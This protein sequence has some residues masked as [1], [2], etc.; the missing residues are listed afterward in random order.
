ML[1]FI[2]AEDI[3][4]HIGY[5]GKLPWHLPADL[6]HFKRMTLHHPIIMGRRTFESFPGLLP[7]RHH[8]LLTHDQK[9]DQQYAQNP[10]MTVVHSKQALGKLLQDDSQLFFIIGGAS[11]FAA[12]AEQVDLLY[13]TK[14]AAN[15]SGDVKMPPIP[16]KFELVWAKR[17]KMDSQ[18]HYP[19]QFKLYRR[20]T[21]QSE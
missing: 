9:H 7:Q 20:Q 13:V 6:A 5:R 4:H 11:L 17:G 10:Q 14:I 15:F 3:Q 8:Y 21:E 2:W 1:A 16:G 12:F 19:Y 18:N